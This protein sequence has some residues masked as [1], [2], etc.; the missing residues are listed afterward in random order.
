MSDQ[1]QLAEARLADGD[2]ALFDQLL[3]RLTL[4]PGRENIRQALR[5]VSSRPPSDPRT[6]K[7]IRHTASLLASGQ[8]PEDLAPVFTD[9]DGRAD[10]TQTTLELR[11]CLIHEMVLRSVDVTALPEITAWTRSPQWAH[12]RLS[13]LPLTVSPVEEKRVLP[14]YG[15]S[16]AAGA[17][18]PHGPPIA[19]GAP[20]PHDPAAIT[21]APSETTT[22]ERAEAMSAAVANW[23]EESNGRIEARAFELAAPLAAPLTAGSPL[24]AHSAV[25]GVLAALGLECLEGLDTPGP[26]LSV[27]AGTPA[28]AWQTLFAAASTGAAYNDGHQGAWGRLAAWRSMG[29]MAGV[30]EDAPFGETEAR[31]LECAWFRF[32]SDA[33]WFDF[34]AWDLGLLAAGPDRRSLAVLAATDTD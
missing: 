30:A 31:V 23:A 3:R 21:A 14:T 6:R 34:I 10:R 1:I 12:H 25:P 33:R 4:T 16:G 19:P 24:T 13:A 27:A 22:P 9:G 15:V 29:A 28:E 5:M 26:R 18:V 2:P 32:S 17:P 20:S 7:W 8:T 11:A